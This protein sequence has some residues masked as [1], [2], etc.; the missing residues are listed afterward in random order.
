M[1]IITAITIREALD[2]LYEWRHPVLVLVFSCVA[3]AVAGVGIFAVLVTALVQSYGL[4]PEK[5]PHGASAMFVLGSGGHTTELLGIISQ[6]NFGLYPTR[7]YVSFSGDT[8]S[9]VRALQLEREKSVPQVTTLELPRART[10]GQSYFTSIF[11]SA[12]CGFECV[13]AVAKVRPDIV[14][15]NGPGSCVLVC[16]AAL[17]LRA[18]RIKLTRLVYVESIARVNSLSLTGR[19]LISVVDRFIVQWPA[20]AEQYKDKGVEYFGILA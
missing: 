14:V 16:F 4:P 11:T 15:C 8:L 1:D 19:I 3:V 10:V 12:V 2:V 13:F 18:T 9:T 5:H 17:L 20:L 6:L 7:T